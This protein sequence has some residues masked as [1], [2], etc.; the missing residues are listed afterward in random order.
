MEL[1]S[2]T[3]ILAAYSPTSTPILDVLRPVSRETRG[4]L[5]AGE[6]F[7]L[8]GAFMLSLVS[9]GVP[10]LR[11]LVLPGSASNLAFTMVLLPALALAAAAIIHEI[12]HFL[13]ACVAGFR[14]LRLA[15]TP[16]NQGA[17][18]LHPCRNEVLP[19]G[20]MILVPRRRDVL[21]NLERRL[22]AVV[23]GGPLLSLVWALLLEVCPY[24]PTTQPWTQWFVHLWSASSA[25][26]AI[27][28][29][30]PDASRRGVYSDGARLLM[31]LKKDAFAARWIA[32]IRMQAALAQG[33]HPREWKAEWIIQ[34]TAMNDHD[35][36]D[37]VTAQWLAYFAATERGD[38]TSATRYLEE[39]LAAPPMVTA[40]L[41]DRLFLE[42][43]VFQ[44][45]FRENP[46]KA[47]VWVE[48]IRL[49]KLSMAEEERLKIALLW[50][51]GSL[52]D[53]WEKL[54][55]HLELI[56]HMPAS[57]VRDLAEKSAREWK[58][59]MESRMLTRAWRTMYTVTQQVEGAAV[60]VPA[61]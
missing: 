53:A 18:A 58:R 16:G 12:G 19:V 43:A 21:E 22:F 25:L 42:A 40:R 59:Q 8:S 33:K 32:I 29:L 52:F 13:A 14:L 46:A 49:R 54:A 1:A 47:R 55:G 41:R 4:K 15:I 28:A 57:G 17:N 5:S 10:A 50:A 9:L 48:K 30:L 11:R 3:K 31:L 26:L 51:E 61:R 7:F 60:S 44:A 24:W 45:W 56:Q 37:G 23:L 6:Y 34:A 39:A 35:T 20:C 38:I 36:R 27:S 2:D